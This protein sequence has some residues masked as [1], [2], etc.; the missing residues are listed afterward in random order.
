MKGIRDIKSRRRRLGALVG[1]GWLREALEK[2]HAFCG[3]EDLIQL[4]VD[5]CGRYCTNFGHRRRP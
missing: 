3:D 4:V 2:H 5:V 1:A